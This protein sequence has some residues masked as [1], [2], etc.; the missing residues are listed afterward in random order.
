MTPSHHA[1]ARGLILRP[2]SKSPIMLDLPVMVQYSIPY[3]SPDHRSQASRS[4]R[5]RM[6]Q[7]SP[8][9]IQRP[10][11]R[12]FHRPSQPL[13]PKTGC[14]EIRT[15]PWLQPVPARIHQAA[16]Q[17]GLPAFHRLYRE[18]CDAAKQNPECRRLQ[19]GPLSAGGY[20]LAKGAGVCRVGRKEDRAGVGAV[21]LEDG[22]KPCSRMSWPGTGDM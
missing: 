15:T 16:E 17:T 9:V 20:R 3:H 1:T 13:P 7:A 2:R 14:A 10:T 4:S 11:R 5:A 19:V 12:M 6:R 18:L 21:G 8:T 22:I